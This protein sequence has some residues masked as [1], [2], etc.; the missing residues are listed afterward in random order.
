MCMLGSV[1]AAACL[2]MCGRACAL[3]CPNAWRACACRVARAR[4]RA[5]SI[6]R[7]RTTLHACASASRLRAPSQVHMCEG[8]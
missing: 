3:A 4:A 8:R 6:A 2:C 1:R 7:V 5:W